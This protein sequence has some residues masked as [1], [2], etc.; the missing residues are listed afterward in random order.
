MKLQKF[1]L[2]R[3]VQLIVTLLIVLTMLFLIFRAMPGDAAEMVINPQM[4]PEAKQALIEQFGLD[5]PLHIQYL[6]YM[7]S[8][9]TLDLGR[10]F[11]TQNPVWLE[12]QPR[13]GPTFLLFGT[14]LVLNYIIGILLGM[15]LAWYRG[16]KFEIGGIVGSLVFRSMP[17]FWFGLLMLY[18]FSAQLNLFP[19]GGIKT[20]GVEMVWYKRI[21]DVLWHMALPLI[22]LT[23]VGMGGIALLMRNSMLDTLGEDYITTARAKG[24]S[25]RNIM[26][27]HAARNAM[28]PIMTSIALSVA[29]IFA[30]GIITEQV[31]SWPG[32]GRLLIQRTLAHDY[33]VVQGVFFVIAV[34]VLTMNAVADVLYAWLDPR[35]QL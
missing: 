25:E 1:M 34:L 4:E 33:P 13:L 31:F 32:L 8:M 16:T 11:R 5:D 6:K 23:L 35:V 7:K 28:L 27:H 12:V 18:V 15:G 30:G 19:V 10:S 17:Y 14:S 21:G 3:A 26:V 20:A 2:G 24:L 22:T 29:L 9:L